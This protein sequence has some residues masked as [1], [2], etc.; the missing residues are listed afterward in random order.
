M[1]PHPRSI[2]ALALD[3]DGTI[4]RPDNSLSERT[5]AA[6]RSCA[7]RGIHPIL[8]TGR[9]VEAA[10]KYRAALDAGGPHVYYN[11]AVVAEMPGWNIHTMSLQDKESALFCVDLARKTGLYFQLYLPGTPEQPR[12][13]LI[14]GRGGPEWE[15]YRQHTGIEVEIGDLE[16]ALADPAVPGCIKSMFIGDTEAQALVRP[17]I[18]ER[19]GGDL[20]I[21]GTMGPFL[22]LMNPRATKGKGLETV[23]KI[24][25]LNSRD[26]MAFG[27]EENDLPMFRA[28]GFSAAPANARDTV[29][30]AAG[31]L[32]GSNDGDG[33]AAFLE[34]FFA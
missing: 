24:L 19:Y 33:V 21:A 3:L 25:N 22:E 26:L 10:E 17:V 4:L 13:R 28:A 2:K 7:E 15:F 23:L 8:C 11:G 29:K 18:E 30:A 5:I 9:A 12:H 20:Y 14:A 27:D 6:I 31:L 1:K 16:A 34:E 32:I